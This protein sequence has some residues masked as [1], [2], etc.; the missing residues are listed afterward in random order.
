ME[1]KKWCSFMQI[2]LLIL[3]SQIKLCTFFFLAV[4]VLNE[5]KGRLNSP[6]PIVFGETVHDRFFGL[7]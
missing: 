4:N 1:A 3:K 2:D 6:G 7:I 5:S